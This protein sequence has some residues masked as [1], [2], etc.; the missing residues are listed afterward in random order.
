M[1]GFFDDN[2]SVWPAEKE[3]HTA[4]PSLARAIEVDVASIEEHGLDVPH[5]REGHLEVP[6]CAKITL[7]VRESR[8]RNS[9]TMCKVAMALAIASLV[10]PSLL[11][12]AETRSLTVQNLEEGIDV[13]V[14]GR[15][16]EQAWTNIASYSGFTQQN[17]VE[18]A[19]ASERTEV[20]LLLDQTTLY[21]GII[22][23]DSDSEPNSRHRQPPR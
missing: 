15:V 1:I 10:S 18:G 4:A 8:N 20:R 13:V 9:Y 16:T 14:D 22:L 5:G 12:S 21:V 6:T 7:G 2:R 17:P 23:F 3:P 19:A 11:E